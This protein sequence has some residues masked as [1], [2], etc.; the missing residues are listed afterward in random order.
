MLNYWFSFVIALFLFLGIQG[1]C[2]VTRTNLWLAKILTAR[3]QQIQRLREEEEAKKVE[4][5]QENDV[6]RLQL[7]NFSNI[8]AMVQTAYA[9]QQSKS[10]EL[11]KL[12]QQIASE[13]QALE[14]LKKSIEFLQ[15]RIDKEILTIKASEQKNLKTLADTYSN[16]TPDSIAKLF[17]EMEEE[18]VIKVMHFISP[19][20]LGPILQSMSASNRS[21]EYGKK[22]TQLIENFRLSVKE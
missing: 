6:C 10:K 3:Q 16:M 22:L 18:T 20:N 4:V 5:S 8:I 9:Q 7:H 17:T 13:R 21:Q 12:E 11:E 2:L 19:E 14:E 1:A 15:D